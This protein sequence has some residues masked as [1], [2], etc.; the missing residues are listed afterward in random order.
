MK[1]IGSEKL[2]LPLNKKDSPLEARMS[3]G[4]EEEDK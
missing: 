2:V 4:A 1:G 3:E